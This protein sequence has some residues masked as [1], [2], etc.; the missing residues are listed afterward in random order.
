MKHA[1]I[2]AERLFYLGG[3]PTTTPTPIHIGGDLKEMFELDA[4]YEENAIRLYK[5]IIRMAVEEDDETTTR[6]FKKILEDEE[7]HDF[8]TSI[9]EEL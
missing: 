9:L 4:K 2:I 3:E 1:E 5:R 8:S 7:H 6:I